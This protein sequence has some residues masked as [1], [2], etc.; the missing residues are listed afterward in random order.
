[1]QH[2]AECNPRAGRI[3]RATQIDARVDFQVQDWPVWS[4]SLRWSG[5]FGLML[6]TQI[7]HKEQMRN[8][9]RIL[10]CLQRSPRFA[11]RKGNEIIAISATGSARLRGIAMGGKEENAKILIRFHSLQGCARRMHFSCDG[12]S[13]EDLRRNRE[14][15]LLTDL[16]DSQVFQSN[17]LTQRI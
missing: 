12:C 16:A 14:L 7:I 9:K 5:R 11:L 3:I 17:H 8:R 13:A 10:L 6:V 15:S 4:A 1:V 2:P